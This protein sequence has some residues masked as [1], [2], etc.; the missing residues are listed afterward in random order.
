VGEPKS[1]V[2]GAPR[3]GRPVVL[4]HGSPTWG[5]LYRNFIPTPV[6]AGHRA[7]VPELV[8]FVGDP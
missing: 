1:D 4:V 6:Q 3:G 7:I 8:R 5:Y 2:D